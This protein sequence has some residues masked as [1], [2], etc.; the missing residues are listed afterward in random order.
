MPTTRA[1]RKN[2]VFIQYAVPRR[3]VPS[4]GSLRE[5][6]AL[7]PLDATLRIVGAREA[8]ELNRRF[9]GK[10][11]ATNVL[12]FA[13]ESGAGDVVL[14]HPVIAREARAQGKQLVAHYAHLVLHGL[15]HLRGYQHEKKRE[16]SRM[17]RAEIRLLARAGF[18]NPYTVE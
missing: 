14:C 10:D 16:A 4:A 3:G 2:R 6:A 7:V 12:S 5:W 15:L 13:Y 11:Y 8:R 18:A 1:R 9:R 17:E